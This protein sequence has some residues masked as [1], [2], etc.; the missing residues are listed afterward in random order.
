MD[1]LRGLA[2][3]LMV[4][5]SME[6]FGILPAWMYHAQVPPPDH[7]FRPDLPGIT[8]VDL[9]FPF[10]LF[11][12]GAAFPFSI[13]RKM[14][15]GTGKGR[16]VLDATLRALRLVVF[17]IFIEHFYPWVI[18]TSSTAV[19]ALLG[20]AA[21]AVMF[22]M[23]MRL[24][25]VVPD[26][27]GAGV[28]VAG[29]LAA[30]A[31]CCFVPFNGTPGLLQDPL[32]F[33]SKSNIIILVLANMAF[34]ASI[35]YIFTR[36]NMI[37]RLLVLLVLAALAVSGLVFDGS[38][39]RKALD[40]R[41]L[42]WLT[43]FDY[44]KYL[45]IVIPGT[46]A[47]DCLELWM[48]DR[49]TLT[50]AKSWRAVLMIVL[51][52]LLIVCNVV[53]LYGRFLIFNAVAS[54]VLCITGI[55]L[56]NGAQSNEEVL[57]K[58]L[59]LLGC[60]LLVLG[61]CVEP[62]QGGIHK[63]RATFSYFFVTSGLATFA[64][65]AFHVICDWY[66]ALKA[67]GFLRLTGQNPMIAYSAGQLFVLPLLALVGVKDALLGACSTSAWLGFFVQGCGLTALVVLTTM[68]FSKIKIF[69]RT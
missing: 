24:P 15:K 12:M 54:A 35:V 60:V 48:K 66:G 58:R 33:V 40:W 9:V 69:W 8:W 46:I 7:I 39:L 13:G 65:V 22:L 34:F 23:Y 3:I 56:M 5:S 44:L 61:L 42:P 11:S 21:W 68:F 18:G 1:A 25:S 2:I 50:G 32:A 43:A 20:I 28:K 41:P 29:Y 53:C 38:W 67:T 59:F 36:E 47:G 62:L 16:L 52:V 6:V 27:I 30:I 57:W 51:P 55:V 14:E 17:A 26:K 49:V 37:A 4:L 10:F 45:F 19:N 63:D 31:M 64:L